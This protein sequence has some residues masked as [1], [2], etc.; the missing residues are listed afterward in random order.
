M[1]ILHMNI[2]QV[3]ISG[4]QIGE[5][6]RKDLGD[7][8]CLARSIEAD[9]LFQPIGI[10]PESELIFGLRRLT[11]CRDILGWHTIPARIIDLASIVHG[12]FIEN[13]ERKDLT[14]S[15]RVAL[16]DALRSFSHGGDRRS[17]QVLS[18]EDE[19]LTVDEAAKRAG[20]G[21]KDDYYR[22][23]KAKDNGIPELMEAIDAGKLSVSL[24]AKIA[25]LPPEDQQ[26]SVRRG[27]LVEKR[28]PQDF[29]PTPRGVTEALL[30]HEQFSASVWEPACGDVAIS[31]VFKDA[32]YSV[33]SSDLIDRGYGD[34]EDFMTSDRRA[35]NIITN[36]PFE[37]AEEFVRNALS[38]TTGKVAM[39]LPLTFLESRK[40][41]SLLADSCL[42]TVYVFVDR[43]SLYKDGSANRGGGRA[44]Y[45]W[46]VWEH[47]YEGPPTLGWVHSERKGVMLGPL[48]HCDGTAPIM[49][50]FSDAALPDSRQQE[51]IKELCIH[52][53][54]ADDMGAAMDANRI[55]TQWAQ[56]EGVSLKFAEQLVKDLPDDV[57]RLLDNGLPPAA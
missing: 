17:D 9:E 51:L 20:L 33:D 6:H 12:E 50:A 1:E 53:W 18:G 14:L 30:Q 38:C 48:Y 47:G 46:F 3:R 21:G 13:S 27:K 42:K 25:E 49:L 24:A 16:A 57:R 41:E 34:V 56:L 15:E 36:P 23:M 26:E 32:G 44:A 4:I 22:F 10:T 37:K 39:F 28:D 43:V 55:L 54:D 29:Y 31:E 19:T 40:R 5:R 2:Q 7:L 45:S 8:E 35:E 52:I 11:A